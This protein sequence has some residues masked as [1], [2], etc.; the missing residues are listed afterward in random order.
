MYLKHL[1]Q[2]VLML[3]IFLVASMQ[4]ASNDNHPIKG[5]DG[6]RLTRQD[7]ELN[8]EGVRGANNLPP[9]HLY[10]PPRTGPAAV[11]QLQTA[12]GST[13]VASSSASNATAISPTKLQVSIS[14]APVDSSI[15]MLG[16][17]PGSNPTL[18]GPAITSMFDVNVISNEHSSLHSQEHPDSSPPYS[19]LSPRRSLSA[20]S[21]DSN[22]VGTPPKNMSERSA[23]LNLIEATSSSLPKTPVGMSWQKNAVGLGGIVVVNGVITPRILV[24]YGMEKKQA[25]Q[26]SV[27]VSVISGLLFQAATGN[28]EPKHFLS[29]FLL[30]L[31]GS[32]IALKVAPVAESETEDTKKRKNDASKEGTE[33]ESKKRLLDKLRV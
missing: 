16:E 26:V 30:S 25:E 12:S 24:H 11:P 2:S 31:C 27:G 8:L 22:A 1:Y 23:Q 28:R 7:H 17:I 6:A 21:L 33:A 14:P 10:I 4:A 19:P 15:V 32:A 5:P 9:R 20:S 13:G 3:S 18:R 29:A